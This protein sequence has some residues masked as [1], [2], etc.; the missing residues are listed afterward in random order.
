MSQIQRFFPLAAVFAVLVAANTTLAETGSTSAKKA[1][2]TGSYMEARTC[3]VYTGPCFANGEMGL[4]GKNAL[5]AWS[6]EA[7]QHQG[8]DLSGLKVIMV[9]NSADTLGHQGIAGAGQVDAVVLVDEKANDQQRDALVSFAKEHSGKAGEHVVRVDRTPIDMSLDVA[10]LTG[11]L[12][13]GKKV[14][15]VTRKARKTDCICSNEVAFYPPL[16]QVKSFVPGVAIEGSYAGRGPGG[17]WSIP[18]SRSAYM[19]LFAY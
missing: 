19:G 9:I 17:H 3:Q 11:N 1:S 15:L 6:V 18:G 10:E 8:V 12:K 16:A 4:T 5:M 2:L 14:E 13:A 7:G